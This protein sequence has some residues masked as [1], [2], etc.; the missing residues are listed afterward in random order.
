MQPTILKPYPLNPHS[1]FQTPTHYILKIKSL[2]YFI[3][4]VISTILAYSM[5]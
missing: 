1:S 3:L 5:L 2:Y 4:Y